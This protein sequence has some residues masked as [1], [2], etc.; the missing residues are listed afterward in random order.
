M[1]S[2]KDIFIRVYLLYKAVGSIMTLCKNMHFDF[3]I[4]NYSLLSPF[5]LFVSL[6]FLNSFLLFAHYIHTHI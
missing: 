5:L 2:T 4:P 1:S 6:L 3:F